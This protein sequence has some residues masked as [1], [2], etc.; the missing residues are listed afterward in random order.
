MSAGLLH[1]V[2]VVGVDFAIVI[3]IA[4]AMV[5]GVF[6]WR[7]GRGLPIFSV[8]LINLSGLGL[9]IALK[10]AI[11]QGGSLWIGAGLMVGG[12]AHAIDLLRRIRKPD[13]NV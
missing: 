1:Q 3:L 5:L 12:I 4:E 2:I 7:T 9:L 13:Q 6:R 8:A 11:T 10:A